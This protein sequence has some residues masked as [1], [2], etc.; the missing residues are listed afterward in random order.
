[1]TAQP[2]HGSVGVS[3][4]VATYFPEAGFVGTDIFTFAAWDG[5]KN[6]TLATGTVAVAQGP[7]SISAKALVPPTSSATWAAPFTAVATPLNV[8]ATPTYDWDF[9]D[10]SAHSTNRYSTHAYATAG[11]FTWSLSARVESGGTVATTNVT[12]T[13]NISGPITVAAQSSSNSLVL[14]WPQTSGDV[15]LEETPAIGAAENWTVSTNQTIQASGA[16]SVTVSNTGSAFFRL[17]KL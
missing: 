4:N 17:R 2:A 9:G 16:I 6:S 10:G 15:L 12:G 14:Q 8:N 1:M 7:F 11:K 13:I 5:S 3:N